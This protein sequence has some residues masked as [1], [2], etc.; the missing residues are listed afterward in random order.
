MV[1]CPIPVS[2]DGG[3]CPNWSGDGGGALLGPNWSNGG[4][5]PPFGPNG[6][7]GGPNMSK[8][9]C[10]PTTSTTIVTNVN[11]IIIFLFL[12]LFIIGCVND[13]KITCINR[14]CMRVL[15][16]FSCTHNETYA[17]VIGARQ[18][19]KAKARILR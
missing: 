17:H 18:T 11:T 7:G 4:G 6:G 15:I 16:E 9:G 5:G 1:E 19:V 10:A 12:F 13:V 3:S 2:V 14:M 8:C